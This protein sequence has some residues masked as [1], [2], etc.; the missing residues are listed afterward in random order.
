MGLYSSSMAV[1]SLAAASG[2]L[3]KINSVMQ[4]EVNMFRAGAQKPR[5]SVQCSAVQCSVYEWWG[6]CVWLCLYSLDPCLLIMYILLQV[7]NCDNACAQ[8]PL[9]H[10]HTAGHSMQACKLSFICVLQ[11]WW[12]TCLFPEADDS[13]LHQADH[14][15]PASCAADRRLVLGEI[16]QHIRGVHRDFVPGQTR[17]HAEAEPGAPSQVH[18]GQIRG[19]AVQG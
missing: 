11:D 8:T 12:S 16:S 5:S 15:Q 19:Q 4:S 1:M 9:R 18:A 6:C 7:N 17:R 10:D 3:F 2:S 14:L 13:S